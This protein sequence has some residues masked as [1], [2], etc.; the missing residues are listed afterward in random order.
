MRLLLLPL[1][2]AL[3]PAALPGALLQDSRPPGTLDE[4]VEDLVADDEITDE[5]LNQRLLEEQA[6]FEPVEARWTNAVQG[7]YFECRE[8]RDAGATP[9]EYPPHPVHEY[10]PVLYALAEDGNGPARLWLIR[11]ARDVI[12]DDE[13]LHDFYRSQFRALAAEN[14]SGRYIP[15]VLDELQRVRKVLGEDFVLE[16]L[17]LVQDRSRRRSTVAR[18]FWAE[19]SLLTAGDGATDPERRA[20]AEELWRVLVDGYPGTEAARFAGSPL[21]NSELEAMRVAQLAW[22]DEV[23]RLREEGVPPEDWPP[24]PGA[25]YAPVMAT[26]A[27]AGHPMARQWTNRFFPGL[28]Q[29]QRAGVPEALG[30]EVGFLWKRFGARN[31]PWFELKYAL[32]GVLFEAFP[33]SEETLARLSELEERRSQYDIVPVVELLDGL[34]AGSGGAAVRNAAR[35]TLAQVLTCSRHSADLERAAA[36]FAQVEAEAEEPD[37]RF[38]AREAGLAHGWT[39]PGAPLPSMHMTDTDGQ[40]VSTLNYRGKVLV[41]FFW[42][43]NLPGNEEEFAF[44]RQLVE[45]HQG[46]PLAVLGI[47]CQLMDRKQ[48]RQR[49]AELGITWRSAL[50][51]KQQNHVA[52]QLGIWDFPQLVVVDA[53]GVIRGRGLSQEANAALV[54]QLLEEQ[55]AAEQAAELAG[56]LVGRVRFV[57]DATPLPPIQIPEVHEIPC[58]GRERELDRTDRTRR[59]SKE[60][61]LADVVVT[62]RREG[63][64]AAGGSRRV[65]LDQVRCRFEPH[66]VVLAPGER[67]AVLNSDQTPRSVQARTRSN[68]SFNLV[69]PPGA[70]HTLELRTPE[71]FQ[72]RSDSHPWMSAWVVVTD[73]PHWAITDADGRFEVRGLPPGSYVAEWW[74]ESLGRGGLEPFEVPAQGKARLELE[75][76]GE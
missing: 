65:V 40:A 42:T 73:A 44:V 41:L 14:A 23:R 72:I 20:R 26:I 18:A 56:G 45:G 71:R 48:Y 30:F 69:L 7:H 67:L 4:P 36:L 35:Y 68:G 38:R 24:L 21:A 12:E 39:M 34:V 51:Q 70:D 47:G 2:L 19:A 1:L 74:H 76:G 32:L 5:A 17:H 9:A 58:G 6:V 31:Q 13:E 54:A 50:L 11:A 60:G 46:Q 75:V 52:A 62:V 27:G 49:A 37:L 53:E 64:P 10:F 15:E 43:L 57:G 25:E 28:E 29:A 33:D 59:V 63:E 8:L 16:A 61:G 22:V 66:V 3:S 55:R